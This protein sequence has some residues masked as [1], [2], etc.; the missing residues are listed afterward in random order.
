ME[1]NIISFS[2][3]PR[4]D[5][6]GIISLLFLSKKVTPNAANIP[7]PRSLVLLPPIPIKISLTPLS[8]ASLISIPVPYV[9]VYN[10]FLLF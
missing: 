8:N 4:L 1:S 7:N 6:L 10:G 3:S 5:P 9:D 2:I